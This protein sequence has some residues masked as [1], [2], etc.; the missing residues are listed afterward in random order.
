MVPAINRMAEAEGS[1]GRGYWP[2]VIWPLVAWLVLAVAGYVPTLAM[3]GKPGPR[4]MLAAQ[5]LVVA[6]VILTLLPAARRM[7]GKEPSRHLQ[8]ALSAGTLRFLLTLAL[9]GVFLWK[10]DLHAGTFLVWVAVTYVV[11]VN[12]EAV[13]LAR[14][15]KRFE[16]QEP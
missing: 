5:T 14:W 2:L 15:M 12:L 6:V 3:V 10:S 4:A 9:A 1:K 16:R 11:V 13:A 7:G 8:L